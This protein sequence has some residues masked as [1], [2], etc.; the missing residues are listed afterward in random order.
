MNKVL[1]ILI[2]VSSFY[3]VSCGGKTSEDSA[4]V[5]SYKVTYP[6]MDKDNFMFEFMPKKM[7]L[8]FKN[9]KYVTNLSAG[10]GLF[11]TSFVVNKHEREFSQLVKLVDKKYKL[12]L[13]DEKIDESIANLPSFSFEH[14]E[15]TKKI[16]NYD[17]KKVIVTVNDGSNDAF[18]IFYTDQI[19]IDTPNW[20]N[21]FKE[22]DGF[23]LEYQY[24]KHGV[25]M[26]FTA[27]KITFKKID[28]SVFDIDEKYVALSE[29]DLNNEMQEIFDSFQ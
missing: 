19:N 22:I 6:K 3:L 9:D 2:I 25:C 26:R 11:K 18:S 10:M 5:V 29:E 27:D 21:Q 13:K 4:G 7:E 20:C 15:E 8:I 28:D 17:C 14:T 23:L 1:Y 16:L 24:E 12:T